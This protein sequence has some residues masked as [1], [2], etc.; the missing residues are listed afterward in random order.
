MFIMFNVRLVCKM[1][2]RVGGSAA[3]MCCSLI[4]NPNTEALSL[5]VQLNNYEYH[6]IQTLHAGQMRDFIIES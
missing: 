5:F 3:Y 2:N 1:Q 6:L 4:I